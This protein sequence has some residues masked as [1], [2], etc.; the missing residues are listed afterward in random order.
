M[1]LSDDPLMVDRILLLHT[2]VL[3][4][5]GVPAIYIN[6]LMATTN[7]LDAYEADG[8]R[9]SINR[10]R[11]EL[12]D[13]PQPNDGTW[14]GRIFGGLIERAALRRAHSAFHPDGAQTLRD[15]DGVLAIDRTSLDGVETITVLCNL[16]DQ[17]R[18]ISVQGIWYELRT[19]TSGADTIELAP[20]ASAWLST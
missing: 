18:A 5:A 4:L 1:I 13:V 12:S 16:T 6:S 17:V 20:Y 11:V 14:Q 3:A 7:D 9:R 8:I 2:I 10:G 19:E 15:L